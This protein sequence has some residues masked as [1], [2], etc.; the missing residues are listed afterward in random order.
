[1]I[2]RVHWKGFHDCRWKAQR[3][4]YRWCFDPD[5]E[6]R[7]ENH[8]LRHRDILISSLK[9][10]ETGLICHTIVKLTFAGIDH[11]EDLYEDQ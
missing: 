11:E 2:L 4:H 8:H 6:T 7:L 1:M 3:N 9:V 5:L 10:V